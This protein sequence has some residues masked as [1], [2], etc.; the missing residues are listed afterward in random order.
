[1][2]SQNGKKIKKKE[3]YS[4]SAFLYICG[5]RS[6]GN[7]KTADTWMFSLNFI[8][9]FLF[10]PIHCGGLVR[11]LNIHVCKLIWIQATWKWFFAVI[12]NFAGVSVSLKFAPAKVSRVFPNNIIPTHQVSLQKIPNK[13]PVYC[14]N[15]KYF[16]PKQLLERPP[17]SPLP[18]LLPRIFSS[19]RC[20]SWEHFRQKICMC[21]YC[22]TRGVGRKSSTGPSWG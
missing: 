1:M 9:R 12:N 19:A 18:R 4:S 7:P 21:F 6:S 10:R 11:T 13:R 16:T 5:H 2:T 22:I 15:N 14:V 17:N 3:N 20:R 8:T